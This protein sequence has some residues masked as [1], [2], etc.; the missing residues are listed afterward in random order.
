MLPFGDVS[1]VQYLMAMNMTIFAE[2]IKYK[3]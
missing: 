2:N 1:Y 3:L